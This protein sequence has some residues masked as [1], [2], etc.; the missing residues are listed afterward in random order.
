[1]SLSHAIL[2]HNNCVRLT[3]TPVNKVNCYTRA[4]ASTALANTR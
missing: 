4:F 2:P 3:F 1:M